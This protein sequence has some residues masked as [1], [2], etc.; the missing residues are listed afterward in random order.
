MSNKHLQ[1]ITG[2]QTSVQIIAFLE[3]L[4][5]NPPQTSRV[6]K[7]TPDV[8]AFILEKYNIDNRPMK[9][10]AIRDYADFM[11]SNKWALTGDTIKFSDAAL[12]RDGQNRLSACVRSGQ[13]FTTHVVFGIDDDYF[14]MLDR[15]KNRTGSDVLIIAGYKNTTMLAA[16]VRWATLIEDGKAKSRASFNPIET[17]RLLQERHQAL[18]D[19]TS[20]G[21]QLYKHRQQPVGVGCALAYLFHKA[22]P[23]KAE[24]FV[25]AWISGNFSKEF[26]AIGTMQKAIAKIFQMSNGRIHDLVRVALIIKAWN[27]HLIN[28]QGR[29][30]DFIWEPKDEFPKINT[31]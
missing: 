8:A 19:F 23:K 24:K 12:L 16:A 6:V 13:P 3:R 2:N 30:A 20:D 4:I 17:L 27:L 26:R 7:F 31:K 22:N 14:M 25:E 18:Q 5:A 15:G 11:S 29:E 21:T 9:P 1:V 10:V 28:K